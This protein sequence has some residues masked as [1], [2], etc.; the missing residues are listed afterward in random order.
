MTVDMFGQI[1]HITGSPQ[2]ATST[3]NVVAIAKPTTLQVGD[4]MIA[5]ISFSETTSNTDLDVDASATDWIVVDGFFSGDIGGADEIGITV[6]YKIATA[7][8]VLATNFSFTTDAAS[9]DCMGSIVAFRGVD[10]ASPFDVVGTFNDTES[11]D[12]LADPI[13]T[14]LTNSAIFMTG[15]NNSSTE[16]FGNWNTTN[17][18]TLTELF[19]F[20]FA[21]AEPMALGGA[22]LVKPTAGS[23]GNGTAEMSGNSNNFNAA[24][25]IALNEVCNSGVDLEL[26]KIANDNTPDY[27]SNVIFT[28]TVTNTGTSPA[29]GVTVLDLLPQV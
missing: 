4:I 11:D 25:L 18:G 24:I 10:N 15:Y 1:T 28:L 2:T 27:G 12:L 19:D 17:P 22:W 20:G 16:T 13:T 21:A 26:T 6:L 8:D 5:T 29:N 3:T 9:E 7:S 23:T 14:T